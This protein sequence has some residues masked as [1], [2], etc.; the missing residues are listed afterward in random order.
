MMQFDKPIPVILPDG[1]E[2]YAIYVTD[3]GMHEN[4]VWTVV[5]CNGGIVRHY[6]TSQIKVHFNATFGIVNLSNFNK[7]EEE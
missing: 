5:H 4:D 2:G 1:S 7:N 3:G 6:T